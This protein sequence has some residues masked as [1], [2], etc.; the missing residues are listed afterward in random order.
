MDS[1]VLERINELITAK[2]INIRKLALDIDI[3][4]TTLRSIL[5]GD[6]GDMKLSVAKKIAKYFNIT[7]DQ[8]VGI[9]D[10]DLTKIKFADIPAVDTDGLTINHVKELQQIANYMKNQK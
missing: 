3:P 10:M 2:K 8:L 9:D 4:Y 5:L 7:L 1:E 6:T